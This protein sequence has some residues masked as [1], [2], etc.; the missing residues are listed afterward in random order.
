MVQLSIFPFL[1]WL[2]S[3]Y[4]RGSMLQSRLYSA[5][6]VVIRPLRVSLLTTYIVGNVRDVE[7]THPPPST[8]QKVF[9]SPS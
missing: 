6:V 8:V 3:H 9:F 5:Q 4:A 1:K 7:E 2:V